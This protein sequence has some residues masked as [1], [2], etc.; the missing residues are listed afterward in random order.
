MGNSEESDWRMTIFNRLNC[1]VEVIV[2]NEP[3]G[4]SMDKNGSTNE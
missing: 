4:R 2:T 1:W 3:K